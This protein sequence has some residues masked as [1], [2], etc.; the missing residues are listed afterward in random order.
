MAKT[1]SSSGGSHWVVEKG[2]IEKAMGEAK[3][4][5]AVNVRSVAI[6]IFIVVLISL[7]IARVVSI[8]AIWNTI[9]QSPMLNFLVLMSGY[10]LG[11]FGLAIVVLTIII[12]LL[13]FPLIARQIR[14]SKTMEAIQPKVRQLQKKYATD[15]QKLGQEIMKLRKEHGI[16]PLGCYLPTLI[17]F[18]IWIALYISVI[19]ALAYTPE[20]LLGL[21]E[22]LYSPLVL[23][24]AVP[25]NHHFLWLDLTHGDI[26]MAFLETVSTWMLFKM[27]AMPTTAQQ[28]SMNRVL[29]WA[30]PLLF[31]F[32]TL[33]LPT[34]LSL[35]WV[36][37]NIVGIILQYPLTG[38]GSL[39]MPSLSML[40]GGA[41]QPSRKVAAKAGGAPSTRKEPGKG[42]PL[43]PGGAKAGVAGSGKK[44]AGGNDV[45][46]KAE[47][48]GR[49]ARRDEGKDSGGSDR[50]CSG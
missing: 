8:T 40:K 28:Q 41:S 29:Q 21:Q 5:T 44:V 46:S 39:R 27:S 9:L 10:L 33:I 16:N 42:V 1:V 25:L 26:G 2:Q 38:W 3:A 24:S 13:T 22:L 49:E 32:M 45:I 7:L 43:K 12:R 36:T 30:I 48:V 23:V 14:A 35:Y 15:S 11:S 50:D 37:S 19:Q 17:Q 6:S 4:A 20:N 31:G 34:G 47:T 18:P